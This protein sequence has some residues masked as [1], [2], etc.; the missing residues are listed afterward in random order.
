LERYPQ[1]RGRFVFVQVGRADAHLADEYRSFHERIER[2]TDRIN[3]RFG[4]EGYQPRT[5][6]RRAPRARRRQ[7]IV[8]CAN[9]AW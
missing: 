5:P 6:A 4:T 2:T 9:S 8:P 7:R 3:K 1:W